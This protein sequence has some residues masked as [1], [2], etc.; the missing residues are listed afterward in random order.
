MTGTNLLSP[1]MHTL[2]TRHILVAALAGC[3]LLLT[4]GIPAFAAARRSADTPEAVPGQILVLYDEDASRSVRAAARGRARAALVSGVGRNAELLQT[5]PSATSASLAALSRDPSVRAV[6]PNYIRRLALKPNDSSFASQWSLDNARQTIQGVT[7]TYDADIDATEA[8]DVTTGVSSVAVAVI[9]TGVDLAHPELSGQIWKNPGESGSGKETNGRDDDGNGYVDDWR[10]WDWAAGDNNPADEHGHGTHV[11]GTIAAK[12]N[13]ASGIAGLAWGSRI[14]ALRVADPNGYSS[15]S[16]IASAVAYAGDNGARV[17]N[18]SM[19]G[20]GSSTVIAQAVAAAS[21]TVFAVAAGNG[22]GDSVGDDNDASPQFPCSVTSLNLLCVAATDNVDALA[23]FSN[24]GDTSVDLAAPGVGILSTYPG[25]TLA[26]MSGT[27]MASPHVAGALALVRSVSPSM[28]PTQVREALLGAVEARPALSGKVASGGRLN[29]LRSLR[30]TAIAA[31]AS[32]TG[33][34]VATFPADVKGVTTASFVLRVSGSST[35]LAANLTCKTSGGTVSPCSAGPVRSATLQ[36]AQALIPGQS[37]AATVNPSGAVAIVEIGGTALA[38]TTKAFRASTS[39][40]EGS[41]AAVYGWRVVPYPSAQGGSYVHER[42]AGAHATYAFTGTSI[43]WYTVRGPEQGQA[44]VKI[45]GVSKGV[46]DNYASTRQWG[47]MRSFTGLTN[48][49]HTIDVIVRGAKSAASTDTIVAIDAY[50]VG[51]AAVVTGPKLTMSWRAGG[52]SAAS[53]GY[54]RV[55]DIAGS[56]VTFIFKG[57][58]F[59]WITAL[60]PD[61]GK[62][63]VY[64]DGSLKG[65]FDNYDA[66]TR[67]GAVRSIRG[68]SNAVH[69]LK[70]LVTGIK[71]SG[72]TG[73]KVVVDRFVVV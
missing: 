11:A 36:P 22:G 17:V 60:A 41:I 57:T 28:T 32:L 15:D 1:T 70:I 39:E 40:Q 47:A 43:T 20:P 45:D 3:S 16:L 4:S 64:V 73:S 10:G 24:F 6:Q 69:T 65:S 21:N 8:W 56:N 63:D 67:Y 66:A 31:P 5:D 49:A 72:A 35:N 26:W 62:A 34:V 27:S 52:A 59:D 7:G 37:Y 53:G 68:L 51:S 44:E 30:V 13:N 18:I 55:S 48:A 12:G 54:Y 46:F 61:M 25:G 42:I 50:K 71:R 2:L 33:S 38:T 29:A 19:S 14:M 58:G 9:D 23:R